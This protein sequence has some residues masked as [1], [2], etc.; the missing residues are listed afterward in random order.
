MTAVVHVKTRL[1]PWDDRG[2][3]LAYE[4]AHAEV[5]AS[6]CCPESLEAAVRVEHLLCERGYPRA[7]IEVERSVDEAL[8]HVAHWT[9]RR[10]G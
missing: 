2:F 10:D 3:V 7:A 4:R 5:E 8:E 1:M 9:V 6:G